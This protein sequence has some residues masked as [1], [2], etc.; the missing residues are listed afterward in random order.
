MRM[1]NI[2]L[3][4]VLQ[5]MDIAS[6]K[7]QWVDGDE[8]SGSLSSVGSSSGSEGRVSSGE[9]RRGVKAQAAPAGDRAAAGLGGGE[10]LV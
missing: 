1:Q 6:S 10:D 8:L 9:N 4:K 3:S 7:G 2:P 5:P